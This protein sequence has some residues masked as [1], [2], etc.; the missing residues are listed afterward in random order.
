MS[1]FEKA[2]LLTLGSVNDLLD[3]VIDLNSPSAVRQQVRDIETALG[4]LQNDA[5]IQDGTLRTMKREKSELDSKIETQKATVKQLLASPDP[6]GAVL[7]R[8]K[9]QLIL[10]EQSQSSSLA[11]QIDTQ[12]QT[13]TTMQTTVQRLAARHDQLVARV[14]QL[15]SL[16]RD[17]KAKELAAS[18]IKSVN[19]VLG[20]A[21]T[22]SIDNLTQRMQAR[23]DIASSK[24]DA[25]V[26]SLTPERESNSAEVD[27]LL[28]SL[29]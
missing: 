27:S 6:N 8:D 17:T 7:A 10:T 1:I 15:E 25:A 24:F 16:D 12:S 2:R 29:K 22:G 13:V 28:A 21:D 11:S 4:K 20:S 3:K 19:G 9:A 23:N 14:H 5:A 26:G 18:A